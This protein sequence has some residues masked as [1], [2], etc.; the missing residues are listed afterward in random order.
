MAKQ[1][2]HKYL[3]GIYCSQHASHASIC[4]QWILDNS[5]SS[6][7]LMFAATGFRR[8]VTEN[9]YPSQIRQDMSTYVMEYLVKFDILSDIRF[10]R[11]S[12]IG[13]WD[14]WRYSWLPR[15]CDC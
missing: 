9:E 15:L 4:I 11:N 8:L 10:V 6:Y 1:K 13:M 3:Q 12:M 7:A 5:Q 2:Q 14:D